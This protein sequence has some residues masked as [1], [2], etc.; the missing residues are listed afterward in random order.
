[1][2]CE[3]DTV[4][5]YSIA[6]VNEVLFFG[7]VSLR[8]FILLQCYVLVVARSACHIICIYILYA[9]SDS[10]LAFY[11]TDKSFYKIL[12]FKSHTRH[13]IPQNLQ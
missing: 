11:S 5:L 3:Y 1:M 7:V 13:K 4:V 10:K 2:I 8:V 9:E 6:E 12:A